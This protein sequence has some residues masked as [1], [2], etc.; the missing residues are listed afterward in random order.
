MTSES[1]AV[2]KS[3]LRLLCSESSV[4]G[5]ARKRSPV[6]L[7]PIGPSNN[8]VSL[9]LSVCGKIISP[10]H[11]H[12]PTHGC[13]VSGGLFTIGI[14][15]EGRALLPASPLLFLAFSQTLFSHKASLAERHQG[16][17][18]AWTRQ[19]ASTPQLQAAFFQLPSSL[20]RLQAPLRY[21][22]DHFSFR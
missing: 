20:L 8:N 12:L 5:N 1:P 13:C 15:E 2:P 16:T 18:L 10:H 11:A 22:A 9:S 14:A 19:P 17:R 6:L 7:G 4:P 21:C 3:R